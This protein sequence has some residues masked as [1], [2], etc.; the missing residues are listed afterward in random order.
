MI[1]TKWKPH[2]AVEFKHVVE[3]SERVGRMSDD[4]MLL[5][6][7]WNEMQSAKGKVK[8][9]KAQLEAKSARIVEIK[10]EHED[11]QYQLDVEEAELEGA[12]RLKIRDLRALVAELKTEAAR[13]N[14]GWHEANGRALEVG[15][16]RTKLKR[17]V[18]LVVKIMG[19]GTMVVET[20]A[21]SMLVK[22]LELQGTPISL[23]P[24]RKGRDVEDDWARELAYQATQADKAADG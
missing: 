14:A 16:E 1:G 19:N 22:L 21:E 8:T 15:M 17:I 10:N 11:D 5:G 23:D 9:L 12:L 3:F 24:K 20:H 7:V 4:S 13:L 2:E 6:Y 18:D